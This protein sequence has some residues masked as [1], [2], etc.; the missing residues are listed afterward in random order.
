[1]RTLDIQSVMIDLG[2]GHRR[3]R[4]VYTGGLRRHREEGCHP[5]RDTCWHSILIQPEGHPGHDDQHAARNVVLDQVV[6]ELPLEDEVNPQATVFTCI[7]II[8]LLW[9]S[10]CPTFV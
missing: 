9:G 4:I 2:V 3:E 1:M 5:Q 8:K 6:G 7:I 10:V